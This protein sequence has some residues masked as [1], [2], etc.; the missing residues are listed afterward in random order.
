MVR[1]RTVT[2][3]GGCRLR[4]LW[5]Q[6][7]VGAVESRI[8]GMYKKFHI[9]IDNFRISRAKM[10]IEMQQR[11]RESDVGLRQSTIESFL[12]RQEEEVT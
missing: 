4:G 7:I 2:D 11:R 1:G 5:N 9:H 6:I 12:A 8:D 3:A 10:G